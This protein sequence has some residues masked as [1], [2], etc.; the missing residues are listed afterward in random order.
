MQEIAKNTGFANQKILSALTPHIAS[1]TMSFIGRLAQRLERSVYTRKVVRSI[2]TAPTIYHIYINSIHPFYGARSRHILG[3]ARAPL[4]YRRLARQLAHLEI[5]RKA[6]ARA[7][8]WYD[9]RGIASKWT[10]IIL[11]QSSLLAKHKF[12]GEEST[13]CR[14]SISVFNEA[15]M[16]GTCL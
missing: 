7:Y 3:G 10:Q 5:T 16:I 6:K 2:R 11:G 13:G 14:F 9:L 8:E 12:G 15:R 1:C 4:I